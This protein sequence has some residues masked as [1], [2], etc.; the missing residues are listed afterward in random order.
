MKPPVIARPPSIQ[1]TL[2]SIENRRQSN[3]PAGEQFQQLLQPHSA[4]RPATETG[5]PFSL[6]NS[7]LQAKA[8]ETG[9]DGIIQKAARTYGLDPN[10]IA[11]LIQ[12]QSNFKS[13]AVSPAG[14]Q[15]LMQLMP[16]TAAELGVS[17]PLDAEENI[18]AGSRYL[19]SLIDRYAG[20]M[21]R[22][23]T[24]Y[25]WGMGNVDRNPEK[26]PAAVERFVAAVSGNP[27][28]HS[29]TTLLAEMQ[30]THPPAAEPAA[31]IEA[32][33]QQARES[34]I[35]GIIQRAAQTFGLDP[36]LITAVIHTES[37]F[38]THAV[39]HA[40]AQGLMQLMPATAAELGVSDPFD[41]EQNVMAGSRYLKGLLDR[42][43]GEPR[44][45]LAAY[46]W[47]MGNLERN[48]E[49]MPS[50]TRNYVAKILSLFPLENDDAST[51]VEAR[52][53]LARNIEQAARAYG[54]NMDR[55]NP[56]F[57]A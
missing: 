25:S 53:N 8:A 56:T 12:A 13:D 51:A 31:R 2:Q 46:N 1:E 39:S 44:L 16:A 36:S 57:P 54:R 22:A 48:P 19:K 9:I 29:T 27:A 17:N 26:A 47:G 52:A 50:E 15:G 18:M 35:D 41:A 33:R 6:R 23:L 20:D 49:R 7:R 43:D 28:H 30:A 4:G 11:A 40:G 42:Y 3:R 24:A 45:A 55:T 10:M 38:D 21:N 37:D 32:I 5:G 14:A 34:G